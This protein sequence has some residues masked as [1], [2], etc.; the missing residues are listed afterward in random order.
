MA[1]SKEAIWASFAL[2]ALL[3]AP[4]MGASNVKDDDG[5]PVMDDAG[6]GWYYAWTGDLEGASDLRMM[7]EEEGFELMEALTYVP[8]VPVM[9]ED[10]ARLSEV[11]MMPAVERLAPMGTISP[12]INI[13][14][15]AVKAGPS[16]VYSP[17][18][19]HDLGYT[20]EGVTIAILDGGVDNEHPTFAGAFVAGADF[21]VPESLLNPRDGSVDP[22]DNEGHGTH[23]ASVALGRGEDGEFAGVAPGAGLI[24]LRIRIAGPTL[25]NPMVKAIEW[26]VEH[27]DTDWGNGYVG[28]DVISISAGL[29]T[30][31]SAVEQAVK[32]AVGEGLVV[33]SAATNSGTSFEDNPNDADYWVDEA[34]IV[35]GTEDNRTV[36]RS[37]DVYWDQS[38]W[39]PRTDDGDPDKY[40]ELKPDL[41]APAYNLNLAAY[42]PVS[43]IRGATG[44]SVGSG[45]SFA[46]PHASG[47]AAL[48]LEANPALRSSVSRNPIRT[49][50]HRTSEARGDPYDPE[51]SPKY[52][53]HYGYGILDAYEA[54]LAAKDY[55]E[56]NSPP[57]VLWFEVTPSKTTPGSV[58]GVNVSAVDPDEDPLTY[59]LTAEAGAVAGEGPSWQWTAPDE[60]GLY[61]LEVTVSDV[62]GSTDSSSIV[63]EVVEGPPNMPPSITSFE[64][65][66]SVLS[67]ND[68]CTLTV[69]ASDPDGE[70]LE[71]VYTAN[72]GTIQGEHDESVTYQAP[73]R[74]GTAR[75]K[76]T[77]M[78]PQGAEDSSDLVIEIIEG[79][80]GNAPV[81]SSLVLT[82]NKANADE[83]EAVMVIKV[84]VT[85]TDNDISEVY[86]DLASLG[87]P[88]KLSLSID[89]SGS[90]ADAGIVGY[91]G[92][93]ALPD[94]LAEGTYDVKV[95]AAD[96][97]GR[98]ASA[99]VQFTVLP[100]SGGDDDDGRELS[101]YLPIMI[102][103]VIG[104]LCAVIYLV[105]RF[106]K[107]A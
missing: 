105:V 1:I 65:S 38:T 54:V 55:V 64:S 70:A 17:M 23:V 53:V 84:Q 50:F 12:A 77:V 103:V 48:M 88:A 32:L 22:D 41:C 51:L 42:S 57:E 6:P 97:E 5:P 31:G 30:E 69:E 95:T 86:A 14:V 25:A 60:L 85:R 13:S 98:S 44:Y 107:K 72:M 66:A 8:A 75:I 35:G 27:K 94:G 74:E 73:N 101:H 62:F 68:V 90:D 18:T 63:V 82:P 9:I 100:P 59:E 19:S 15:P 37:D 47:V 52:N 96:A 45:T 7:L 78:D 80:I 56:V 26:C 16:A 79:D 83:K 89:G 3:I 20:G 29:G 61:D 87:G 21:T 67:M 102:A 34:I 58:C 92:S 43:S 40:D 81:I 76:V 4:V 99:V 104:P 106:T 46:T 28:V 93:F 36:D 91:S 2:M 11:S 24:D 33:I 71:Y 10:R 49:I 39:G